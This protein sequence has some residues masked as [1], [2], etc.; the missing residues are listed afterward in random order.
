MKM[1]RQERLTLKSHLSDVF[2][3][4]ALLEMGAI[5]TRE[6]LYLKAYEIMKMADEAEE[7]PVDA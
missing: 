4:A 6:K 7:V 3:Q 1:T 2:A 5:D